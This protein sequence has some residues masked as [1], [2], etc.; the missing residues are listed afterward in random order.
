MNNDLIDPPVPPGTVLPA[1]FSN[2]KQLTENVAD[3]GQVGTCAAVSFAQ[4]VYGFDVAAGASKPY[5]DN[6]QFSYLF[7]RYFENNGQGGMEGWPG[8]CGSWA[9]TNFQAL[10]TAAYRNSHANGFLPSDGAEGTVIHP[11]GVFIDRYQE[12]QYRIRARGKREVLIRHDVP[13]V[14]RTNRFARVC[15]LKTVSG[16]YHLSSTDSGAAKIAWKLQFR[17]RQ[18]SRCVS[19]RPDSPRFYRAPARL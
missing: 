17:R 7:A 9:F 2:E 5:L 15:T 14:S 13:T 19:Q 3:Q 6:V 1:S 8:D 18:Q 16:D 11:T 4:V 10:T 12:R